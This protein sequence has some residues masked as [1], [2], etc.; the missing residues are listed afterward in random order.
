M[1]KKEEL[2]RDL[3]ELANV[4]SPGERNLWIIFVVAN[5]FFKFV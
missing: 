3:L 5:L 2:L 1:D 4:I